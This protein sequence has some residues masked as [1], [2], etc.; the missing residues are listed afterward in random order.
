MGPYA[1]GALSDATDSF[2]AGLLLL[3]AL[4]LASG[5]LALAARHERGLEEVERATA[6]PGAPAGG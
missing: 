4:I 1:V 2:Y 5:L 3:A 6:V